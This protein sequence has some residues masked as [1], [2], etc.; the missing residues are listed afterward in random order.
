M[1]S[2]RFSGQEACTFCPDLVASRSQVV[3]G[4]GAIPAD[5]MF[6]SEAP[7]QV[8][9]RTGVPLSGPTGRLLRQIC[10][11]VGW[12]LD[13]D[14]FRTNVILCHPE[15]NRDP[16]PTEVANCNK[17]LQQQLQLV[18]PKIIIPLGAFAFHALL[19]EE[20]GGIVDVRG[21]IYEREVA[22]ATRIILPTIHPAYRNRPL[23][24]KWLREDLE[25]AKRYLDGDVPK[26]VPFRT[27]EASWEEILDV[28]NAS[29]PYAFDVETDT[30]DDDLSV[31]TQ[32]RRR[33]L[34]IIGVGVCHTPGDG[35]YHAFAGEAEAR[36]KLDELRPSLEDETHLKV[37]HNVLFE[38]LALRSYGITLRGYHDTLLQAWLLGDQPLGLENAFHRV[39]GLEPTHIETL[40]G[41][42]KAD[43][44][45]LR[46]LQVRESGDDFDRV[47]AYAAE[48]PDETWRLFE[49]YSAELKDQNLW[50]LYTE[51]ELPFLEVLTEMMW[52]GMGFDSTKL[53]VPKMQLVA[54]MDQLDAK[55]AD[56][57]GVTH[58]FFCSHTFEQH[59][60]K[61][62][63]QACRATEDLDV[64]TG[65]IHTYQEGF[66]ANSSK[67]CAVVLFER[68]HPYTIP[69][70]KD[71]ATDKVTLAPF[72][73]NPLV[74]GI[75]EARASRRLAGYING[76]PQHVTNGRIHS[77][78][79]P[80]GAGTGRIS[81]QR[82]NVQNIP[83]RERDDVSLPVHPKVLR[84]AFVAGPDNYLYCPD[85]SGIEM[86]VE[87]HLSG[88]ANLIQ[89]FLDGGDIHANTAEALFGHTKNAVSPEQWENERYIAKTS[90]FGT[91]FGVTPRG[92]LL[93]LPGR[94]LTL[95]DTTAFIEGFFDLFP[96]IRRHQRELIQFC[97]ENGYVESLLGR[98][99]WLP[100]IT[101]DD[102]ALRA[103][104]ENA[105][106]NFPVQGTAADIFKR[107]CLR[108][109]HFLQDHILSTQLINQVH[110][111]VVLEG[112]RSELGLLA[113]ELPGVLESAVDLSVPTPIDFEYGPNWGELTKW[114]AA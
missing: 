88:D 99:R 55:L 39:F 76:L 54:H 90:G 108:A 97:R 12:H 57:A 23:A 64:L 80:T 45:N 37:A 14:C 113:R 8:E 77:D 91:L 34:G 50:Q 109:L 101:A 26:P 31:A 87:A 7:G 112:P 3:P 20:S 81:S 2:A 11:E 60:T 94:G 33:T 1:P 61:T 42:T 104:A 68:D 46:D 72:I 65:Y 32:W 82:P 70:Q 86:R 51:T 43:R 98:R 56:L 63:C 78:L 47:V 62:R 5:I 17:W 4:F 22:G 35:R 59:V 36:A 114:K 53:D 38:R 89:L 19:P 18:N 79:R 25:R 107:V 48:D 16:K 30:L 27:H 96:G 40:I 58:C 67:Q 15:D 52:N 66:N 41:R 75:L 95:D 84:A 93:R 69:E 103:H 74:Q 10:K 28:T 44:V 29:G 105:A 106:V 73:G 13:R 92:L 6:V 49:A 9:D 83:A 85:L 24:M 21:N 111:E 100:D 102:N 71:R 110:D